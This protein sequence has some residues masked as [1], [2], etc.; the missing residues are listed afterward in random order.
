MHLPPYVL[1]IAEGAK[2]GVDFSV[3]SANRFQ[4]SVT[5]TLKRL[6]VTF[7]FINKLNVNFVEHFKSAI[8]TALN[9]TT[10]D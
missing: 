6:T 2:I 5:V 8:L 10:C 1:Q 3:I 7:L 4:V 9:K